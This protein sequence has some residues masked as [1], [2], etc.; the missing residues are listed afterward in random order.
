MGST[1]T[2]LH[3]PVHRLAMHCVGTSSEV[4]SLSM[5][6][7]LGYGTKQIAV[8]EEDSHL[9]CSSCGLSD[10]HL[11]P[12]DCSNETTDTL[13]SCVCS[14]QALTFQ[15]RTSMARFQTPAPSWVA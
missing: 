5:G 3:E 15:E 1:L 9:K 14:I 13:V 4:R 2:T 6:L 8:P 10:G 12:T 11:K 7:I